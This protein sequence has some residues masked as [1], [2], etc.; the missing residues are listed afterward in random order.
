MSDTFLKKT[1]K[2]VKAQGY[3]WP[4]DILS[5][6]AGR[7]RLSIGRFEELAETAVDS[8]GPV[9]VA[10]DLMLLMRDGGLFYRTLVVNNMQW[11]FIRPPEPLVEYSDDEVRS[12]SGQGWESLENI[13]RNLP[14]EVRP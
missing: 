6:Q 2:A 8:R 11:R 9:Q 5:I 1:L 10:A 7:L 12:L 14:Q 13:Q 4:D 3:A